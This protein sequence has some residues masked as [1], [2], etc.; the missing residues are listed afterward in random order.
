MT[1]IASGNFGTGEEEVAMK[2]LTEFKEKLPEKLGKS[3][4]IKTL[5]V[6][7]IDF[8]DLSSV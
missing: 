6:L 8:V 4:K 2:I 5:A 3:R 7:L 1:A